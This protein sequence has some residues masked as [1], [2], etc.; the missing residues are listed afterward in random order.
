[1][2]KEKRVA[3]MAKEILRRERYFNWQSLILFVV[4]VGTLTLATL[5]IL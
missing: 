1:M 4:L 2:S 3:E 5:Y